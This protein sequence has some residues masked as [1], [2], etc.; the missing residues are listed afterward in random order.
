MEDSSNTYTQPNQEVSSPMANL[1]FKE[2]RGK[3]EK[4]YAIATTTKFAEEALDR[5]NRDY[6]IINILSVIEDISSDFESVY[7]L[8][9]YFKEKV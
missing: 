2:I 4:V 8:E 9:R 6:N 5:D 1:C 7:E 3:L